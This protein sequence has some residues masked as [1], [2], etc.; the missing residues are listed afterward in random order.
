M[1]KQIVNLVVFC[2]IGQNGLFSQSVISS[3]R[4]NVLVVGLENPLSIAIEGISMKDV[5]VTATQGIIKRVKHNKFA[6]SQT[7]S[8]PFLLSNTL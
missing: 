8:T 3:D 4:M 6:S 7:L 2:F 5:E 1:L